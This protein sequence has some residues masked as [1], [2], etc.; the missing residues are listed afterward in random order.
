MRADMFLA[1]QPPDSPEFVHLSVCMRVYP[2]VHVYAGAC[3]HMLSVHVRGV[4][5]SVVALGLG[6]G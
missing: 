3:V 4:V 5:P 2:G 1:P 6:T